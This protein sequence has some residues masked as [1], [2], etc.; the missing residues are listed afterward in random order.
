MKYATRMSTSTVPILSLG[1]AFVIAIAIAASQLGGC[2]SGLSKSAP[3]PAAQTNVA[4]HTIVAPSTKRY[5]LK[6]GITATQPVPVDRS[7]PVYPAA[8]IAL[9]LPLVSVHA[10]VIVGAS[11]SPGEVRITHD[12]NAAPYPPEFD[13]AVA[14]SV[15]D[16]KYTPLRFNSWKDE[17]DAHGNSIGSHQVAGAAKPFSLDYVFDFALRDGKPVVASQAISTK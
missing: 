7:A 4:Y 12:A 6:S 3:A 11:G 16:W 9:R 13:D 8:A 10:K 1:N 14:A 5:S 15:L 17:Y 2:A